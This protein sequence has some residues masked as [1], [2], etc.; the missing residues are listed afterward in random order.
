MQLCVDDGWWSMSTNI[1]K[2]MADIGSVASFI[3]VSFGWACAIL[4]SQGFFAE[5]QSFCGD[6]SKHVSEKDP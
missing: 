4:F 2:S 3:F 6:W 5:S 1:D